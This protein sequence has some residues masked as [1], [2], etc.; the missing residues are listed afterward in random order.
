[1]CVIYYVA[2]EKPTD[3]MVEKAYAHNDDG[4]GIAWREPTK[5]PLKYGVS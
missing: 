3:E 5:I 2:K 1:M 4:A